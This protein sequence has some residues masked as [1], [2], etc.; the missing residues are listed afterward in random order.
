MK[1]DSLMNFNDIVLRIADSD[2]GKKDIYSPANS[3][4]VNKHGNLLVCANAKK[5]GFFVINNFAFSDLA[6]SQ[7]CTKLNIPARYLRKCK[8]DDVDLFRDNLNHWLDK[9]DDTYLLRTK[10]NYLRAVLSD[11]YSILDNKTII[12]NLPALSVKDLYLDDHYFNLRCVFKEKLFMGKKNDPVFAGVNI[13]NSEVGL[14]RVSVDVCLY[15]Q[16]CS[17][18]LIVSLDHDNLFSQRHFF[19]KEDTL[20][21]RLKV[22]CE[23]ALEVG[24]SY[25]EK[26]KATQDVKLPSDQ[27]EL[28]NFVVKMLDGYPEE[29]IDNVIADS[30]DNVFSLINAI[31]NNAKKLNYTGRYAAEKLAGR[32]VV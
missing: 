16:V 28:E 18:G 4:T 6:L 29:F 15:R 32:L 30:E 12:D 1:G 19:V 14:R 10:G 13:V 9:T 27:D 5:K 8:E 20:E 26:F 23:K 11:K 22:A 31:T 17:N 7:L 3:L 2:L 25:L 24:S 21:E